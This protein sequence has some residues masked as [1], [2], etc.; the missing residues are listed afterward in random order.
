MVPSNFGF[1]ADETGDYPLDVLSKYDRSFESIDFLSGDNC[2]V[3]GV[4]AT[5]I[6]TH[7][8]AKNIIKLVPLVGFASHRLNLSIRLFYEAP[9][10]KYYALVNKVNDLMVELRTLKNKY[11]L[12]A[13]TKLNPVKRNDTRWGS[14]YGEDRCCWSSCCSGVTQRCGGGRW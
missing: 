1:S 9:N 14:I 12:A 11:K 10:S 8:R 13:K 7:L 2:T 3:N 5:K 4:L 6:T